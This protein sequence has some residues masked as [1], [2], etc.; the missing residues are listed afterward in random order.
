MPDATLF[1]GLGLIAG[2][3]L[4]AILIMLAGQQIKSA[5][6]PLSGPAKSSRRDGDP[7]KN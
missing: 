6:R 4:S 2:S 3:C 1:I 7:T 5:P